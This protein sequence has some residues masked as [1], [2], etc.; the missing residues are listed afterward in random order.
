MPEAVPAVWTRWH[1]AVGGAAGP[2][3]LVLSVT[4]AEWLL[5][6]PR[7]RCRPLRLQTAAA[8]TLQTAE[9]AALQLPLAVPRLVAR[10]AL[11][12]IVL[13]LRQ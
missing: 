7:C 9:A 5:L 3:G 13:Q 11:Q 4:S 8:A 6:R 10:P 2:R 1:A 12:L